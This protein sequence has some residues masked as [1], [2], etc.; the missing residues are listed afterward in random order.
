MFTKP[1]PTVPVETFWNPSSTNMSE[2]RNSFAAGFENTQVPKKPA[3][4]K[5]PEPEVIRCFICGICGP[6][7][8]VTGFAT[9]GTYVETNREQLPHFFRAISIPSIMRESD[10]ILLS[11]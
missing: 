8:H 2:K 11:D 1:V 7:E 5:L 9:D 6:T 10:R 4:L 3:N